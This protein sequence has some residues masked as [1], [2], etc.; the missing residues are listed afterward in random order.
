MFSDE[1]CCAWLL[2]DA[3]LSA[4]RSKTVALATTETTLSRLESIEN[5][6]RV[7]FLQF[8]FAVSYFSKVSLKYFFFTFCCCD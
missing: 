8:K 7:L 2:C 5:E 6:T 4:I 1:F 3:Q